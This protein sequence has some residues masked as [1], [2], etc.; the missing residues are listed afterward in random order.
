M[1]FDKRLQD[2]LEAALSN[3]RV[4]EQLL[5]DFDMIVRAFNLLLERLERDGGGRSNYSDLRL[6][7]I[8][9]RENK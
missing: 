5:N 2:Q 6:P 7:D 1:P 4:K 8:R 3:R 9:Q